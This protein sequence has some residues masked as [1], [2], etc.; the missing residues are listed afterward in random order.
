V[1]CRKFPIVQKLPPSILIFVQSVVLGTI[2]DMVNMA[3]R[4]VAILVNGA[5]ARNVI[6]YVAIHVCQDLVW[7]QALHAMHIK[8]NA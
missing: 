3:M 5:I 6:V 7:E 4:K 1:L 2:M 8:M